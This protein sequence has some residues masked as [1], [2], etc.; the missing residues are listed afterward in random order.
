MDDNS[1]SVAVGL[2]LGTAICARNKCQQCDEEVGCYGTHGLSCR[3]SEG[4]HHRHAT[5]YSIVHRALISANV[6]S[7]LEPTCMSRA[8]GKRP[9]GGATVVPW[10]RG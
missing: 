7:R 3:C 4:K 5:D 9:D 6:L 1:L 8:N 2:W 10:S